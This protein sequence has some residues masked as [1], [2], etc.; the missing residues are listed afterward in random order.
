[1]S[2]SPH[3]RYQYIFN[4]A[5]DAEE[6]TWA[7]EKR[8]I[9]KRSTPTPYSQPEDSDGSGSRRRLYVLVSR[10]SLNAKEALSRGDPL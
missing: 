3:I 9:R 4:R 5:P 10:D 7:T 2:P 8:D 6:L 1:M